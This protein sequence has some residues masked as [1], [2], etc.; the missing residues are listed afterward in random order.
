MVAANPELGRP[1]VPTLP[2]LR[3]EAVF[4]ARYEM[5]RSVDDILS[6]RT[7]CS[8][9]ARDA[10]ADAAVDVARLLARELGWSDAVTMAQAEAYRSR[11]A[12]E[13]EAAGLATV[14]R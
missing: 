5:A 3:A 14:R 10:S 7:R 12:A 13:R 8:I 11:A 9:L 4:G 2:Y 6:R 1:L